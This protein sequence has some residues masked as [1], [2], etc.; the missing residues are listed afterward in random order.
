MADD[1]AF[2]ILG[3]SCEFLDERPSMSF[4][5]DIQ[6]IVQFVLILQTFFFKNPLDQ[7]LQYRRTT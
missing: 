6:G 7:S 5:V 3:F 1:L 2:P 4:K